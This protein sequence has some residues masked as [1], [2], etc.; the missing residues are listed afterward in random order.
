MGIFLF[1]AARRALAT[2]LEKGIKSRTTRTR[3]HERKTH[4]KKTERKTTVHPERLKTGPHSQAT[5][6]RESN[7]AYVTAPANKRLQYPP[8]AK[9]QSKQVGKSSNRPTRA[10][11]VRVSKHPTRFGEASPPNTHSQA[12]SAG[13]STQR[14]FG[15]WPTRPNS[16]E[17]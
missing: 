6:F 11:C 15:I 7:S 17:R 16:P 5:S 12:Q 10:L 13:N 3:L 9:Q 14:W 8:P 2:Q 1:L 4:K